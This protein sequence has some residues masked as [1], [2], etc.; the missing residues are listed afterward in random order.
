MVLN[1]HRNKWSSGGD[2]TQVSGGG[3]RL[4]CACFWVLELRRWFVAEQRTHEAEVC[5]RFCGDA[6]YLFPGSTAASDNTSLLLRV[7]PCSMLILLTGFNGSLMSPSNGIQVCPL[8]L[9]ASAFVCVR[10]CI[11]TDWHARPS[12]TLTAAFRAAFVSSSPRFP[13]G[14]QQQQGCARAGAACLRDGGQRFGSPGPPTLRACCWA[15]ASIS[16]H[17]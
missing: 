2:P 6:V 16:G 8:L 1:R 15:R 5:S 10:A 17:G 3:R 7:T 12:H 9:S 13:R 4:V 11:F 14:I